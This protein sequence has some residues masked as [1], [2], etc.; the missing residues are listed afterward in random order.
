MMVRSRRKRVLLISAAVS[1]ACCHCSANSAKVILSAL[2][3]RPFSRS[4]LSW[5]R[6]LQASDLVR[7]MFLETTSRLP[8]IG[9]VP[10]SMRTFQCLGA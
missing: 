8:V 1:R 10:R 4:A 6:S 9:F 3:E 2:A 5:S 7:L